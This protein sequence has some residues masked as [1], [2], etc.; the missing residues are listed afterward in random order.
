MTA[1]FRYTLHTLGSFQLNS[2]ET[3]ASIRLR[4][5]PR[6][7]LAWLAADSPQPR[8]ALMDTFCAN[9]QAPNRALNVLLSRIRQ[10]APGILLTK[11]H[12]VTLNHALVATDLALFT[13]ALSDYLPSTS[14]PD[15]KTAVSLYRGEFLEG[16][17]LPD[18]PEFELWLLYQRT[19]TRRLL[20][21]GLLELAQRVSQKRDYDA[22]IHYAHQL[23]QTNPLFEEA[24]ALLVWLYAQTGQRE[25]AL[26]QY[27]QCRALLEAELG[28]E[29]G[30]EL[31]KLHADL[32]AGKVTQPLR[33]RETVSLSAISPA[34]SE[35][36][37]RTAECAQLQRM[38]R[39]A[40]AGRG[41][42]LLIGGPAGSGKTRLVQELARSLPP[43]TVYTGACD[44]FG[45]ALPYQPW[46][47]ILER[48]LQ[49]LDDTDLRQLPPL[50][51]A[52][53]SLLL[54]QMA[55]RLPRA[56]AAAGSGKESD[57]FFAAITDFLWQ[58]PTGENTPR[59]FFLDDLQ[60]ADETS[61][62]LLH[63]ISRRINHFPWLLIGVY[64]TEETDGAP[65]LARLLDDFARR[66]RPQMS[67]PP[68]TA[69]DI[70]TLIAH[71]WP[72][73]A[74]GSRASVAAM[75]ARATGG[76]AL[77]VT[78][79]L[80]ELST[81]EEAPAE[82]PVPA[83][84]RD[85]IW[86]RL[87]RLPS[88]ERQLLE[89]LAVLADGAA[90]TQLQQISA[91]SDVETTQALEWGERW[92]VVIA[93]TATSGP[94]FAPTVY[95]F[96]HDLV[97][98]AVYAGLPA[99]R[100]Q[101]LHRRAALWFARAAQG[102]PE[103]VRQKEAGRILHHAQ[104]GE[105]FDLVF[106][107]APL[108][109]A[110]AR[111]LFAY[112]DAIHALEGMRA[113]F[114][115][116]RGAPG[117][118]L[119]T[120]EPLLFESLLWWLLDNA[121]LGKSVAEET[122]VFR[123]MEEILA[124]HPDPLRRAQFQF[125]EAA[126]ILSGQDKIAAFQD[127][128]HQ[129]L[130][131]GDVPTAA[132]ALAEAARASITLSRNRDG[133]SLYEQ[134]FRLYRQT[135]DAAGEANCLAGLTWTAINLGDIAAALRY[136]RQ[137]LEISREQG[138]RRGEGDALFALTAAWGF[139]YVP[140]KIAALAG[141][142]LA[143]YQ[144]MGL[145][146]QAI[147]PYLFLGSAHILRGEWDKAATVYEDVL[148]Q[149]AALQD[150]W[151]AGWAAQLAGRIYLGWGQLEAAAEKLQLA[152]KI[153]LDSGQ[154]QNQISDL[155]WMGRLALARENTQAA[156]QRTAQAVAQL[157]AGR[158]EFYV[159]EQP[160]VLMCRAEALAAAGQTA[161]ALAVA[162]QAQTTLRRFARQIN[163]ADV[164]AQF[165]AYPLNARIETAVAAQQI[166]WVGNRFGNT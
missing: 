166:I 23:L 152:Q 128:Q 133:R 65:A 97:R 98:E 80:Q 27:D 155:A 92:G 163:D 32:L 162:Q 96:H 118:D 52:Y 15:L 8:S 58:A 44:E 87:Q 74:A 42:A 1:V 158:G 138:D 67:L 159:W 131:L 77:F 34:R 4:R 160:D 78:A 161:A 40:Q 109:A 71:F 106:Q 164:L 10:A 62:H 21:R 123:Q 130:A 95:R 86:R 81:A 120:A 61:L 85:V 72:R 75:L 112:Q 136:G 142:A 70:H 55:R 7:L 12:S 108:A 14:L 119:D 59:L 39:E 151:A 76:N 19:H 29:P 37:G 116:L 121:P 5:K 60:W 16:M 99:A 51:Q 9:A 69:S 157:D 31:E 140:D 88:G 57:R 156:L 6:A 30:G 165:M 148:A 127:V 25:A 53:M 54:P 45:R 139:Y 94:G 135:G 26:Q 115:H 2:L 144:D 83:T 24:H 154:A 33:Q 48:R 143:L 102:Q 35:F 137:A 147:R 104:R 134:A 20:E 79:V 13:E 105:A 111:R 146:G 114:D 107:W 84:V 56:P 36:V 132:A 66:G 153:R 89:A 28:V 11:R 64:R 43:E 3:G 129:F 101:Q 124:R 110:R 91:R 50:T 73:L 82:L 63:Y 49:Q 141:E 38:W 126:V 122:A 41:V 68:L 100:K 46:L 117:F 93:Q 150:V 47:P 103:T 149:A 18:A 125:V 22:A 145:L 17:T 113:A 90:L